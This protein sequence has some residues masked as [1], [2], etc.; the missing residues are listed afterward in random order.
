MNVDAAIYMVLP[1][2]RLGRLDSVNDSVKLRN[3]DKTAKPCQH[4]KFKSTLIIKVRFF[5]LTVLYKIRSTFG[6]FYLRYGL[7]TV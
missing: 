1:S 5:I 7:A 6:T 2:T 3:S 4:G